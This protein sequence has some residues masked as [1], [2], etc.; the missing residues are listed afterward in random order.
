MASLRQRIA[1]LWGLPNGYRWYLLMRKLGMKRA[2]TQRNGKTFF[3]P[4]DTPGGVALIY[5]VEK[6]MAP[7]L[8][9]LLPL[10]PGTFVDVGA[11]VG[12]TL[13][14][15]RSVDEQRPWIG[16]EPAPASCESIR[17]LIRHNDFQNTTLIPAGLSDQAGTGTLHAGG[18][19]DSSA[20]IRGAGVQQDLSIEVKL[21]HGANLLA[22]ELSAPVGILK[23]D[24][25]GMELEVIRGLKPLLQRDQPLIIFEVLPC[26]SPADLDRGQT[27]TAELKSLNYRLAQIRPDAS[28]HEVDA[29]L[30]D[31]DLASCNYLAAPGVR[32]SQ[33]MATEGL[34]R[35]M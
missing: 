13:L 20:T 31:A 10:A 15:L 6:W 32:F 30:P 23:V 3:A 21:L 9:R 2:R 19:T 24:V 12:Q 22:S 27:L 28:L 33:L 1:Y 4:L 16:F 35:T 18:S 8:Q 34:A 7:L 5:P 29:P 11:N 25:E 26:S 14:W 17:G